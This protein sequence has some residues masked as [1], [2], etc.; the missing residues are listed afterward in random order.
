[1]E[2]K[3]AAESYEAAQPGLGAKFLAE[4]KLATRLIEA[5]PLAWAALSP[6]TRRCRIHRFPYGL[7]YHVRSDEIL[8]VSVMDL[9]RDPKR[10]EQY[11]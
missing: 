9:R 8:I 10:W 1:M 11:L 6:R 5:H 7:F 4:V 3:E 2:L